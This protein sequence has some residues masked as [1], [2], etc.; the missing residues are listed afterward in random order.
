M[1]VVAQNMIIF[2][3]LFFFNSYSSVIALQ[4]FFNVIHHLYSSPLCSMVLFITC[5]HQ[6]NVFVLTWGGNYIDWAMFF[7]LFITFTHLL[8]VFWSYS[9]PV[10]IKT[11][12]LYLPGKE[13]ILIGRCF[14]GYSSYSSPLFISSV[15][16]ALIHH[17]Y[18]SKQ[19]VCTYLGRKLNWLGDVFSDYS[20]PIFISSVSPVLIHQNNAVVLTWRGNYID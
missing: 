6:S 3:I 11:M 18:S 12:R 4:Y 20:S 17:P 9:S 8:C 7:R 2:L 10:F 14:P 19:C 1:L 16:S 13:I 5:I 15:S